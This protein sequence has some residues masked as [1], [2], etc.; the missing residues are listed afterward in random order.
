M[1]NLDSQPAGEL[2]PGFGRRARPVMRGDDEGFVVCECPGCSGC[3]FPCQRPALWSVERK[4]TARQVCG[5][6]ANRRTTHAERK[7]GI[8]RPLTEGSS[9]DSDGPDLAELSRDQA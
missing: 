7:S 3:E 5:T 1:A 8:L 6:C 4:H 9:W 2:L